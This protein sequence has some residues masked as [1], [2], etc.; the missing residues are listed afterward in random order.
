MFK[1]WPWH[2]LW[3]QPRSSSG[4]YKS[5]GINMTKLKQRPLRQFLSP[6]LAHLHMMYSHL[7]DC[8]F[9]SKSNHAL[10]MNK[11]WPWTRGWQ[12]FNPRPRCANYDHKVCHSTES[13]PT[14][15]LVVV[16]CVGTSGWCHWCGSHVLLTACAYRHVINLMSDT[17][18]GFRS[19]TPLWRR[20]AW[21]EMVTFCTRVEMVTFPVLDYR[22]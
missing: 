22:W 15:S 21:L 1:W 10:N 8:L 9:H 16:V 4:L 18:F 6:W 19:T 3:D 11:F 7:I 13:T 2:V 12:P 14:G 17:C 5:T 20:P